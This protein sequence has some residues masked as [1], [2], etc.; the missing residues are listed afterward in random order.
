[1]DEEEGL[2][3]RYGEFQPSHTEEEG[4]GAVLDDGHEEF[5]EEGRLRY[6]SPNLHSQRK[7]ETVTE[8]KADADTEDE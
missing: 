6:G 2:E 7:R 4:A 8:R 1:M 5:E 3:S